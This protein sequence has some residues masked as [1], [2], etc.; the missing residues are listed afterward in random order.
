MKLNQPA[1]VIISDL[2]IVMLAIY[3]L[4]V[5]ALTSPDSTFLHSSE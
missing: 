3:S 4:S 1:Y 2:R 5:L